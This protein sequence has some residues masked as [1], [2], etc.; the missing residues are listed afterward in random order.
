M[1]LWP[2]PPN[3]HY[4][5][6][7]PLEK[8]NFAHHLLRSLQTNVLD[9]NLMTCPSEVNVCVDVWFTLRKLGA[10]ATIPSQRQEVCPHGHELDNQREE[11][12]QLCCSY[13]T[14]ST[15]SN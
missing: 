5:V 15:Y 12:G 6:Y 14:S 2:C 8:D 3:A 9:R 13:N 11:S 7:F 4:L 10:K 1:Q